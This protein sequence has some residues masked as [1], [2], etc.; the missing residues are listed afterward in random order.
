MMAPPARKGAAGFFIAKVWSHAMNDEEKYIART[1][2]MLTRWSGQRLS[3]T[4]KQT[5]EG[6]VM[7]HTP[8]AVGQLDAENGQYQ[9]GRAHV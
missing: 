4:R 8:P 9:I 7:R 1:E 6:D 3:V 5:T 2:R